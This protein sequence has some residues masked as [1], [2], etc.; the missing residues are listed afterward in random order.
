M[1]D[2]VDLVDLVGIISLF[3]FAKFGDLVDFVEVGNIVG[4]ERR[5]G[6]V[7]AVQ[8]HYVCTRA[9]RRRRLWRSNSDRY[10]WTRHG[11]LHGLQERLSVFNTH[12]SEVS[13]LLPVTSL[14][15]K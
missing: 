8:N 12:S 4:L 9:S 3:E 15:A 6:G 10:I 7:L 11:L 14:L 1:N 13:A 2:L 5:Q